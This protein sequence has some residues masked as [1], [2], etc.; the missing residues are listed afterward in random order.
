LECIGL[1]MRE[2]RAGISQLWECNDGQDTLY[3]V[4]RVDQNPRELVI[5]AAVGSGLR[6]F[7]PVFLAR[8]REKG[9]PVRAHVESLVMR[10][11]LRWIGFRTAEFVMRVPNA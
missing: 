8:A 2:V 9:L 1:L 4:T 7:A 11:L 10:R 5:C 3:V 6:K